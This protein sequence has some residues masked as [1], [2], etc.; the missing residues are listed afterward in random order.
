M[1]R[2]GAA[3]KLAAQIRGQAG[4]LTEQ[5]TKRVTRL[6][7]TGKDQ[8]ASK[9]D[10]VADVIKSVAEPTTEQFGPG[11]SE[12]VNKA[13]TA[14]ASVAEGLRAKS[15]HGLVTGAQSALRNN[16][17]VAIGAAA[18]IGFAAAR[19]AKGGLGEQGQ[20][21]LRNTSDQEPAPLGAVA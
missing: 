15:V 7:E 9:L 2:N 1:G 3:S 4:W 19:I 17:G 12:Y 18:V 8:L 13:A 20:Q 21:G 16:T 14:V 10:D 6:A 11:A 5:G